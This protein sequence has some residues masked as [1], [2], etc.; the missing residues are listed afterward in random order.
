MKF[1]TSGISSEIEYVTTSAEMNLQF[2]EFTVHQ[3][4]RQLE[5]SEKNIFMD[6]S[7]QY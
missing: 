5:S 2:N 1:Q 4:C 3:H 6:S 7:M